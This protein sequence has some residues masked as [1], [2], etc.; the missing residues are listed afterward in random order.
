MDFYIILLFLLYT[1]S[2]SVG[3]WLNIELGI[4]AA[5]F[6]LVQMLCVYMVS[7]LALVKSAFSQYKKKYLR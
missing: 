5:K 1:C 2:W 3:S 6:P 7:W 4:L